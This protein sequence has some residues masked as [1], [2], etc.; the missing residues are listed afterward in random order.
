M[1]LV[2]D[3]AALEASREGE[4]AVG[5]NVRE[6]CGEDAGPGGGVGMGCWKEADW[7]RVGD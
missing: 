7:G 6:G 1:A 5:W 4:I 3:S 2:L